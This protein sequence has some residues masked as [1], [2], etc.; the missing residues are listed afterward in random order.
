MSYV[1]TGRGAW[2]PTQ[3]LETDVFLELLFVGEVSYSTQPDKSHTSICA[4]LKA[5]GNSDLTAFLKKAKLV[6]LWECPRLSSYLVEECSSWW[7][8]L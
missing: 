8:H 2:A 6:S 7:P 1:M 4:V 5:E 3:L